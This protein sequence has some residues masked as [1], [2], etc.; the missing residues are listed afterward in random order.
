VTA[1]KTLTKPANLSDMVKAT[2]APARLPELQP[3]THLIEAQRRRI[4]D[5]ETRL[6]T[7]AEILAIY[8]ESATSGVAAAMHTEIER[9]L[10]LP[11][12]SDNA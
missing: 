9:A 10:D 6:E 12:E 4:R 8:N 1:R 7:V 5:L 11:M 2:R 3:R